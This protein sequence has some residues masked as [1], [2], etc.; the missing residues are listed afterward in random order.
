MTAIIYI[1]MA[2]AIGWML[3]LAFDLIRGVWRDI[4]GGGW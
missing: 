4:D 3:W 1:V 2:A